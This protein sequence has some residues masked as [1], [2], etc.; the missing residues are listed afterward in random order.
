MTLEKQNQPAIDILKRLAAYVVEQGDEIKQLR[1]DR[2]YETA[3]KVKL[4]QQLT[5]AQKHI[6]RLEAEADTH[7]PSAANTASEGP[8]APHPDRYRRL[9]RG[10]AAIETSPLARKCMTCGH[11]NHNEGGYC[12]TGQCA[13]DNGYSFQD[14]AQITRR[15]FPNELGTTPNPDQ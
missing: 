14:F 12:Q 2:E 8:G 4:A 10:L 9:A 13:C 6:M 11:V 7:Q 5:A 3:Q 15:D 1:A